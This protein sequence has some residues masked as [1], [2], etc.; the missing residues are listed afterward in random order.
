MKIGIAYGWASPS[1][2]MQSFRL[3]TNIQVS[4]AIMRLVGSID[5]N[6]VI[7]SAVT[8]QAARYLQQ[9]VWVGKHLY[10]GVFWEY[11]NKNEIFHELF[12]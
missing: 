5:L 1:N 11:M 6:R 4:L 9:S 8:D 12:I 10:L 7:A 3:Y 2:F